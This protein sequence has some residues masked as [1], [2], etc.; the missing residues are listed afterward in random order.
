LPRRPSPPGVFHRSTALS[1]WSIPDG[2]KGFIR[3]RAEFTINIGLIV[4]GR[5]GSD[6]WPRRRWPTS[7][8]LGPN[9]AVTASIGRM[10]RWPT[11]R[12]A[13]KAPAHLCRT[14]H[15][16]R[17]LTRRT[18]NSTTQRFLD[19]YSVVDRRAVSSSLKFGLIA[20]GEAD[21]YPRVGPTSE[22][23]TA[24]G[25]A[26]LAAAG[27]SV[28]TLDGGALAYGNRARQFVNPDFV[29]WARQPLPRT[30]AV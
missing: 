1:S 15:A 16:L 25:H 30:R 3:G 22:W 29:A 23:D 18:L 28:T 2:T 9:D 5:P 21:L 17:A 8:T 14:H 7:V 20:K 6:W 11:S 4:D 13:P 12:R 10:P 19:G 24:A 27:G 26:V